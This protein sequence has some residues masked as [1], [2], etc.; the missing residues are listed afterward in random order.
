MTSWLQGWSYRKSKVIIHAT[1]AGTNYQIKL[2]LHM[3]LELI[4]IQMYF[5]M[6][7]VQTFLMI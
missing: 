3:V 5:L 7:I 6:I 4:I 2:I 1:D